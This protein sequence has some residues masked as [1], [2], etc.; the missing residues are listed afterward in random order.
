MQFWRW[1][2]HL[3]LYIIDIL[4]FL[5]YLFSRQC[6]GNFLQSQKIELNSSV[7]WCRVNSRR[8]LKTS[9][10]QQSIPKLQDKTAKLHKRPLIHMCVRSLFFLWTHFP[11]LEEKFSKIIILCYIVPLCQ[12]QRVLSLSQGQEADNKGENKP[13]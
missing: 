11:L 1:T 13:H 12:Y 2:T 9:T 6:C 10:I 5:K 3:F 4:K 8:N 7:H